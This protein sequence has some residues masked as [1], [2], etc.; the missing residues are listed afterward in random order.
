MRW[1]S[2]VGEGKS[3]EIVLRRCAS[4]LREQLGTE[5]A[6]VIFLFVSSTFAQD[7]PSIP[8]LLREL[9]QTKVLLGCSAAGVI[10]GGHELEYRHAI[11]VTAAQLPGVNLLPFHIRDENLPNLDAPPKAWTELVGWVPPDPKMHVVPHFVLL[12]DP[13]SIRADNLL[14]GLDFAF[15]RSVKVGGLASG[16][17]QAGENALFLDTQCLRDGAVGVALSGNV[18]VETIV[19]QGCRPI[20]EPFQVTACDRNLLLEIN[21]K[22]PLRVLQEVVDKLSPR[23]RAL[24]R[25]ALFLGIVM[26]PMKGTITQGDFLIRNVMGGDPERGVLVIGALLR[27]GQTVQFHVRDAESSAADLERSLNHYVKQVAKT[28]PAGALLFSC[29]GR[30]ESL[31]GRPDHDTE[32]AHAQLGQ[33]PLGGFFCN[34]EIGPVSGTTYLHGYTSSF[35]LFRPL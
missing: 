23:D 19:A 3:W 20:G 9:L 2:T 35:G 14:L 24:A 12:A 29:L 13:F 32:L 22:P 31:Y 21:H 30:G 8:T 16:A 6:D 33:V 4:E 34:G 1:A 11:S 26:D 25:Q 18:T 27:P 28:P 10:G 5:P 15:P 17:S 7:Y